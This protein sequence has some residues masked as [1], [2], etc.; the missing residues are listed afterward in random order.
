MTPESQFA[1][2]AQLP[3]PTVV[4]RPSSA[5][6]EKINRETAANNTEAF[7]RLKLQYDGRILMKI[8]QLVSG[9]STA[10]CTRLF[11]LQGQ[12][13]RGNPENLFPAEK[14]GCASCKCR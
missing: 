3:L 2:L 5:F 10:L 12:R 13:I 7:I 11:G 8:R 14:P 1:V 4:Q 9:A 6:A